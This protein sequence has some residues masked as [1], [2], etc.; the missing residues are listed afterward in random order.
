MLLTNVKTRTGAIVIA[1]LAVLAS[2]AISVT[3]AG[4]SS[5]GGVSTLTTGGSPSGRDHGANARV[6]DRFTKIWD[7]QIRP[8]EKR[9]AHQTSECESGSDPNAIGGGGAYRGAFQ[10]MRSTWKAAPRSP[11]GDPIAYTYRTQAVVAV[12]LKREDGAGHWPVCGR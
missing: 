4:A 9:W 11:G 1:A 2:G 3:A 12:L 7:S 8:A 10:F 6:N 5:S